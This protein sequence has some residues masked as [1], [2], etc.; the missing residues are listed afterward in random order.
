MNSEDDSQVSSRP[1]VVPISSLIPMVAKAHRK[2]A[3]SLLQSVDLAAGQEFVLMLLWQRSPQ[4]QSDLTRQLMVEPPTMAKALT[5]LEN[6]G[7]VSR[8]RSTEDRRVLLVSLTD[9][10]KALEAPVM[11]VWHDLETR[12]TAEF[13]AAEQDQLRGLLIRLGD[14]LA[15]GHLDTP[16]AQD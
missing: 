16:S 3:G 10:G 8:E 15:S 9:A 14:S 13:T 4:S 7:L 2:L 1:A 11:A 5:R 6:L 12:T